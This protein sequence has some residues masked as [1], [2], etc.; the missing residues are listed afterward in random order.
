MADV[1]S[2][3]QMN[4]SAVMAFDSSF[5]P[6]DTSDI[7]NV[8]T[9]KYGATLTNALLHLNVQGIVANDLDF[10]TNVTL[11]VSNPIA[12]DADGK[13][14]FKIDN[15]PAANIS[16]IKLKFRW[17]TSSTGM[18]NFHVNVYQGK[19]DN[20]KFENFWFEGSITAPTA[21]TPLVLW[22]RPV[23]FAADTWIDTEL[24]I[25]PASITDPD[26]IW[27]LI[28]METEFSD[29]V[30]RL[31]FM[32]LEITY[33]YA[34]G[35]TPTF[36]NYSVGGLGK[37]KNLSIIQNGTTGSTKYCYRV[38]PCTSAGCGPP[39][40]EFSIANGNASLDATDHIC[41]TWLDVDNATSYKIYRTCG[42]AGLGLLGTVL[43]DL[44]DCGSGGSGGGDTGF[45]DDGSDCVTDCDEVFN[46]EDFEPC[47]G[48]TTVTYG[49]KETPS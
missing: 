30:V 13:L 41:I 35:E 20:I 2:S 38:V 22:E 28:Q 25:T 48:K 15:I 12:E 19:P 42:P 9:D 11:V 5:F 44:G 26:D 47:E 24:T 45:K 17:K 27:V 29:P 37:I 3:Y 33:P 18:D 6:F 39:S 46:P 21:F 1:N 40:D 36:K 16:A 10:V 34:L 31:S 4:Q 7:I 14:L 43:T 8:L 23:S 32:V 49:S